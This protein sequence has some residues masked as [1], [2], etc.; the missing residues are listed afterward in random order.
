MFYSLIQIHFGSEF[1]CDGYLSIKNL[2]NI[3]FKN[4]E[5]EMSS[6]NNKKKNAYLVWL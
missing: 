4:Q 5:T 2:L 6:R 3:P 1:I